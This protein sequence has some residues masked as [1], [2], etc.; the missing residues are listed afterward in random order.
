MVQ[1]LIITC[2]CLGGLC[3][4]LAVEKLRLSRFLKSIPLR[5]S[6][7]GTRGKSGV[8]RLL[9]SVL[10][11]SGF[12][13]LGKVTGSQAALL[14]PDGTETV[15]SRRGLPTILEGKEI[16]RTASRFGARALVAEMMSIQPET[17]FVESARILKPQICV[18]TNVR[19]DHTDSL[20][21]TREQAAES[22]S[23]AIPYGGCVFVPDEEFF[24]V[25]AATAQKRGSRL[26]RVPP[27]E[28]SPGGEEQK[29]SSDFRWEQNMRL[30]RAVA[31]DLKLDTLSVRRG[32]QRFRPDPGNLKI[33][34]IPP[35]HG[36]SSWTAVNAFAAN[37]PDS[38]LEALEELKKKGLLEHKHIIGILNLRADRGDRTLQWIKAARLRRLSGFSGIFLAGRPA[39]AVMRKLKSL[40]GRTVFWLCSS[41]KPKDIM[42][43]IESA[44]SGEAVLVGMGNMKG[45]GEKLVDYWERT[46]IP[47][48]V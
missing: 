43:R 9:T 13:T 28:E 33:W 15:L 42:A 22:F 1:L 44:V 10:K 30:V 11:E 19:L 23:S 27:S 29:L 41:T 5:I 4:Y 47:H 6:I 36:R 32:L 12:V 2:I 40:E 34:S 26:I 21:R 20:G 14:R 3:L 17:L 25:F 38:T 37:D 24:P 16:V 7:T 46:G 48:G 8:T 39:S 18:L 31:R 45:P 35:P